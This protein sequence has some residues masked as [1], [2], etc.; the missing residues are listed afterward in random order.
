MRVGFIGLGNVGGKLSG[1]L[2]RNGIDLAVHDL[3]PTLVAGFVA[4][5]ATA[6]ES[7]ANLMQ[8][9]DAVITCL[10][11]PAALAVR[12]LMMKET[13]TLRPPKSG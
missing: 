9:C 13:L 8:T 4:K 7:P 12:F 11:S 5:G 2:L 10:P 3:D 1:S 6:G